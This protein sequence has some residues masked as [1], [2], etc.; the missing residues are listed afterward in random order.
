[1]RG[2]GERTRR[3][4][5]EFEEYEEYKEYKERS[6]EGRSVG[7]GAACLIPIDLPGY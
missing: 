3:G 1:M 7:R 5:K 2:L 4:E 6:Q